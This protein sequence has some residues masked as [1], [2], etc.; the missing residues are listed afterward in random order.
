[1]SFG[2]FCFSSYDF[3]RTYFSGS[4][5]LFVTPVSSCHLLSERP[6]QKTG[7]MI[8]R[9]RQTVIN[10][11]FWDKGTSEVPAVFL[12]LSLRLKLFQHKWW[13]S[14]KWLRR[15]CC[16]S[17]VP[18]PS[19]NFILGCGRFPFWVEE[20]VALTGLILQPIDL[21]GH[22]RPRHHESGH[23]H[24]VWGWREGKD[25]RCPWE[26]YSLIHWAN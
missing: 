2:F 23:Q 12:E 17:R 3:Q 19:S 13:C 9:T 8:W 16:P 11:W 25:A 18:Y 22:R 26:T 7:R 10:R 21:S 6:T 5:I 1:M 14:W 4:N 24:T 20:W 15:L